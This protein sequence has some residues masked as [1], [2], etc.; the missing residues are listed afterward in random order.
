MRQIIREFIKMATLW[1]A[2]FGSL[3][4]MWTHD[5][6]IASLSHGV[7]LLILFLMTVFIVCGLLALINDINHHGQ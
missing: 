4:Y 5:T 1:L 2:A 3:H 7:Q 6:W